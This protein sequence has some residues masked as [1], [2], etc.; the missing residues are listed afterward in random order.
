MILV[1]IYIY[2]YIYTHCPIYAQ[3]FYPLWPLVY[4]V[5][6]GYKSSKSQVK[7][8]HLMYIK[9][10][11]KNK[12]EREILIQTIRIQSQDIGMEFGQEKCVIR[13]SG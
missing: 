1:Y 7:V 8:I 9:H 11:V 5:S 6:W 13:K 12:K 2:I 4:E 10:I 3:R